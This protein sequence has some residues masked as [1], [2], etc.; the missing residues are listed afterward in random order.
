MK[1]SKRL[2]AALLALLCM[3]TLLTPVSAF[4]EDRGYGVRVF[5]GN[6]SQKGNNYQISLGPVSYG[7]SVSLPGEDEVAPKD[8]YYLKGFVE[9]GKDPLESMITPGG[10][11]TVNEDMDFVAV[12]GVKGEEVPYTVQYLI[13][14][15]TTKI[16]PD[17]TFYGDIGSR[18]VASYIYIDGYQPYM[19]STKTLTGSGDVLYVYYT[20]KVTTTPQTG[21]GGGGGTIVPAN[22]ASTA[23]PTSTVTP[24]STAAPTGTGSTDSSGA[25]TGVTPA[26]PQIPQNQQTQDIIDLDKNPDGTPAGSDQD[27]GSSGTD[28]Q[29]QKKLPAAAIAGISAGAV[30]LVG[31]LYWY[32]LFHLKKKRFSGMDDE[33]SDE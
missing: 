20:K 3:V 15:T 27:P 13:Y 14:N 11:V 9:S 10:S 29:P 30:G 12:Y 4:A 1:H 5:L 19:R 16:A 28:A 24:A 2:L 7:G 21:G 31:L 32:L 6:E 26:N 22:P 18:P 8:G 33:G 17:G 25:N 23:T